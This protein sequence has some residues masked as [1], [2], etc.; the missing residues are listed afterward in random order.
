MANHMPQDD[1]LTDAR[2]MKT[3]FEIIVGFLLFT[4]ALAITVGSIMS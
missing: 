1:Q 2:D 3:L 4:T